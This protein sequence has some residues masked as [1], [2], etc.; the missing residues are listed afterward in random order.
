MAN[1]GWVE[2][3]IETS[4]DAGELLG[5]LDSPAVSGA[6]QDHGVIRLYWAADRWNADEA[7][8]LR[9]LLQVMDAGRAAATLTVQS[10]PAQ[11]WNAVWARSVTPIRIGQR[12]LVRPSWEAA[13]AEPGLIDLVIDPKLAFGTGHHATT[14]LLIEWLEDEIQGGELVLDVGTGTGILAMVALR[15]GA[16]QAGG[17]DNDPQAI[18]CA[19][20]YA[21]DNGFGSE[22]IFWDG[23]LDEQEPILDRRWNL[24]LANLDRRTLLQA[25]GALGRVARRG[26]T[27]LVSG[28]LK[29]QAEE[30]RAAF[31]NEGLYVRAEREREGWVAMRLQVAVFCD[32]E[33]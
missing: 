4:L 28:L 25:A 30:M 27:V 6:W 22:L 14:Q 19:R 29:E 20:A 24:V 26:A 15:L 33:E 13:V 21:C 2:I 16:A 3:Q 12:V 10:I 8:R 11:D 5:M 1:A 7:G 9:A 17:C 31:A 32:G 18:E 23:T